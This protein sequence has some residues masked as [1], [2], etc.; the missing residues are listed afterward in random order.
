MSSQ[1]ISPTRDRRPSICWIVDS[2]PADYGRLTVGAEER[3]IDFHFLVSGYD[4]LRRWPVGIPNVCLVNVQLPGLSG[5]DLVEM[6]RPF[7]RGAIVC[8][9][10][11][12]YSAE[13]EVRALTL[14]VHYYLCKPLDGA[15]ILSELCARRSV[16]SRPC[17]N[18]SALPN[19]VV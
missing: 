10:D 12:Q 17:S 6:L 2:R 11:D 14:G 3:Q 13:N 4:V 15:M 9:V 18:S 19:R 7:P 16:E 5:F 1:V 8:M